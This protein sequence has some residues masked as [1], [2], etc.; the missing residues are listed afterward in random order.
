VEIKNKFFTC[1]KQK[2]FKISYFLNIYLTTITYS[3]MILVSAL[4][5]IKINIIFIF[6]E[7]IC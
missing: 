6:L 7:E 2:Y 4:M 3:I 1:N 5:I